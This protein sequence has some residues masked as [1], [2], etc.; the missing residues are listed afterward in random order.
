M[1]K[2]QKKIETNDNKLSGQSLN[3]KSV[4]ND[5]SVVNETTDDS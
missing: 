4:A 2:K 3:E 5:T 1:K